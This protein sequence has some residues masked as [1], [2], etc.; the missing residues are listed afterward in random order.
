[1]PYIV[2]GRFAVAHALGNA[3]E[4]DQLWNAHRYA[5]E[6]WQLHQTHVLPAAV[7]TL[8]ASRRSENAKL[9]LPGVV[10]SLVDNRYAIEAAYALP[11]LP[12]ENQEVLSKEII[13]MLTRWHKTLASFPR[14]LKELMG[15]QDGTVQFIEAI[16]QKRLDETSQLASACYPM[17]LAG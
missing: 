12:L 3:V 14:E 17:N 6:Q 5:I 16:R 13:A 15:A 2:M 9:R 1:M 10:R 11:S 7:C 4:I 8:V